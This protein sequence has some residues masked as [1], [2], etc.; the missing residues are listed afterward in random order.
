VDRFTMPIR[1]DKISVNVAVRETLCDV[2]SEFQR[3][4]IHDTEA[5]G[6]VLLLDGHIQL[7]TTDE[8]AYHE[9]LVQIPLL[10]LDA[11]KRVLI[12]GGGDGGVLRECLRHPGVERVDMV[13]IDRAVVDA[14][15]A[16]LPSVSNGAFDDPRANLVVGDAFEFVK[17]APDS[18]YDLIVSDSTDVYEGE[19]GNLSEML[20]TESFYRDVRRLLAPNGMVVTQADNPVFCGYSL[21]AI[22]REFAAVFPFVGDYFGLVPSFG[23]Y[24]AYCYASEGRALRP[25][26]DSRGLELRYLSPTTYALALSGAGF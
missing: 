14:C 13:E 4:E 20:F 7:A 24:S 12:V 16:H 15:R 19:E 22:R 21:E 9:S 2:R 8:H 25:D 6:R 23:G 3:I 11:P 5:L 18:E 1:G 26:F 10:S 17:T